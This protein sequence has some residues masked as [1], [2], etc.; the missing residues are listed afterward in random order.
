MQEREGRVGKKKRSNRAKHTSPHD[1]NTYPA[2]R[3]GG[4]W[5]QGKRLSIGKYLGRSATSLT[6]VPPRNLCEPKRMDMFHPP[7][8]CLYYIRGY[9]RYLRG[10]GRKRIPPPFRSPP[11][12]IY[13]YDL[14]S[15]ASIEVAHRGEIYENTPFSLPRIRLYGSIELP[16]SK[17]NLK[18]ETKERGCE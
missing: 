11:M 3:R 9:D 14:D 17:P 18:G 16:K 6:F 15:L 1:L 7:M 5:L 2:T 4:G 12:K 13:S 10:G 8:E